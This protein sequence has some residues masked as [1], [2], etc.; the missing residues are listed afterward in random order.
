MFGVIPPSGARPHKE[1]P[2]TTQCR[3]PGDEV[4]GHEGKDCEADP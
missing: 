2:T 4:A 1:G 3:F